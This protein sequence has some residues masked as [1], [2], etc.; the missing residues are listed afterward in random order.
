MKLKLTAITLIFTII[1]TILV[2]IALPRV[3]QVKQEN[4]DLRNYITSLELQLDLKDMQIKHLE[5]DIKNS[6]MLV[7]QLDKQ[8]KNIPEPKSDDDWQIFTATAYTSHDAGVNEISAIGMNI[9]KWS[10]YFNFVAVDPDVIPYGSIVLIEIDDEI[11]PYLAVDCGGA[12]KGYR[13]DLY[14]QYDL[15]K[16]FNWGV[17]EVR[18]RVIE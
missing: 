14:M 6:E 5:A 3:E 11:E 17:R 1:V 9:Y 16:A 18:A 7:R 2:F 10:K 13:L 8:I 15:D 4:A 12:I